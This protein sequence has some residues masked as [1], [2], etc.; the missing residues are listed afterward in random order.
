MAWNSWNGTVFGGAG[1]DRTAIEWTISG[2]KPDAEYD[3]FVYGAAGD[4]SR[5]F[6]MTIDGRTMNVPT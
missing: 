6:D 1:P 3:M 2:R 5:S 4:V